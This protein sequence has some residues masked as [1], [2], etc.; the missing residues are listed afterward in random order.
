MFWSLADKL[1]D[2]V[3]R[4]T[5]VPLCFLGCGLTRGWLDILILEARATPSSLAWL[6]AG[7]H[8]IM[9]LAEAACF[10][11]LG[12]LA[13]RG[14]QVQ[15]SALGAW[16]SLA[17]PLA[18]STLMALAPFGPGAEGLLRTCGLILCGV[19][20]AAQLL[21]WLELFGLLSTKTA[22]IAW[23]GSQ[24][25]SFCVWFVVANADA[26]LV[27]LLLF[28]LPVTSVAAAV[29]SSRRLGPRADGTPRS[30]TPRV[31]ANDVSGPQAIPW[32]LLAWVATFG[33]LYGVADGVNGMAF[34]TAPSRTGMAISAIIALLG[35]LLAP[36]R[37]DF[38]AL[39]IVAVAGMALGLGIVFVLKANAA[40]S[41][42]F[43]SMAN[44][45]YLMF[46]HMFACSLA[47]RLGCSAAG[48]CGFV[49]ATNIA[50]IQ[51]GMVVG[52]ALREP[53]GLIPWLGAALGCGGVVLALVVT[54]AAVYNR[55]YLDSFTLRPNPADQRRKTLAEKA[56]E[57]ALSPKE[58]AV[59]YLLADGF[60]ASEI[61]EELFLA[62]STVRAH[63]SN[64]YRK[65]GIH[66]RAEFVERT[67]L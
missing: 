44:E 18:G 51:I 1:F 47:Y 65:M 62:P 34:S 63:T 20:Y 67:S 9:A 7:V 48:A 58:T 5:H 54:V 14:A 31:N 39:A 59:F 37:F 11:A 27:L 28:V 46:A 66:T 24:L 55:D 26:P 43:I 25:V 61:G 21:L 29:A 15:A 16:C 50:A 3:L 60:T 22:V 6:P 32:L 53:L 40:V 4:M 23:S 19:G 56:V 2:A 41:Q 8:V 12:I 52:N 13:K 17:A 35:V 10:L 57:L 49:G 38:K 36:R 33:L 30:R 42:L 64:I 45:S